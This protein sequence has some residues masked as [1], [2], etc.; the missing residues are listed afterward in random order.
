MHEDLAE[1]KNSFLKILVSKNRKQS[2]VTISSKS[3]LK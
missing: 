3:I 2:V 1:N